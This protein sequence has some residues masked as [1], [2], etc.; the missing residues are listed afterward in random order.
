MKVELKNKKVLVV[1]FGKSGQAAARYC[2][3]KGARLAV[4]DLREKKVF[5]Y[6]LS[7][8]SGHPIDW[9]L[10]SHKLEVFLAADLIVVSPGVPW[11]LEPLK[12][13]RKK[14]I[15]IVGE[16]ELAIADSRLETR[17]SRP[18][19]IAVTGTNGKT[20]TVSLIHHLLQ[21][22]GKKSLLAGNVGT[23][24]LDCL[25][26]IAET[27]FLVLE[28]SSYQLE[29]TPSL[30]PDVAVWL[31][32]TED[33]LDWHED[34]FTYVAAKT[35]LIRQASPNGLVIYNAEDSMVTQS[36]EQIPATRFSFSSKRQLKLG[37]WV[38]EGALLLKIKPTSEP[39]RFDLSEIVLK[40]IHNWENMLAALLAISGDVP[41]QGNVP[42]LQKALETF[43]PLP[44][45]MQE[46]RQVS[47]VTYI[48]DSKATNVGAAVKALASLK[49]PIFWIAGG[50]D[51]GGSYEPLKELVKKKSKKLTF[52][53]KPNK[54]WPLCSKNVE[55]L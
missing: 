50:R 8:F 46:V 4:T 54:K 35:K 12:E 7:A 30:K 26:Q 37:G 6:Q 3:A 36:V 32:V 55:I 2:I 10:G 11:N 21:T 1:G 33:H 22:A 13:A 5:S 14:G 15:P 38:E 44:H 48:N 16:M 27:E 43:V 18:K 49:A 53:E 28:V 34:F 45:R 29:T 23:P 19:I 42:L 52:L 20:T 9:Y 41:L 25:D 39:Q 24:L 17:D 40:G 31:N 47:G 51:K